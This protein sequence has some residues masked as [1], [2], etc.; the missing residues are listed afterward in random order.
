MLIDATK[1]SSRLTPE[2]RAYFEPV[3]PQGLANVKLEDFLG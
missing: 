2:L 1:G 3:K